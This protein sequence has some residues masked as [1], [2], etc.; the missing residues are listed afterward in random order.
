MTNALTW[1]QI[2]AAARR[3]HL[4]AEAG[5]CDPEA[6][7]Q[8]IGLEA[9]AAHYRELSAV[10]EKNGVKMLTATQP[11]RPDARPPLDP[12]DGHIIIDYMDTI[13]LV[14]PAKPDPKPGDRVKEIGWAYPHSPN[15]EEFGYG[16]TGCYT[17]SEGVWPGPLTAVA[18]CGGVSPLIIL[19]ER[20]EGVWSPRSMV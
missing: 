19:G 13:R 8:Q 2:E 3:L 18:G 11:I 12:P 14:K 9:E 1:P 6:A 15:A 10:C 16:A 20:L 5:Q 7:D 17:L 4:A